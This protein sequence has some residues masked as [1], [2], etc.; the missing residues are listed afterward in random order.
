M[1]PSVFIVI[2]ICLSAILLFQAFQ[3]AS[4]EFTGAK[5]QIQQKNYAEAERLLEADVEKNPGNGEG[6]FWLGNVRG[7]QGDYIGMNEAYNKSLELSQVHAEEIKSNKYNKWAEHLNTGA[8]FLESA[9]PESSMYFDKAIEEFTKAA[10]AWPDTSLTYRYIGYTYNNASRY[11]EAIDAFTAAWEKGRDAESLKRAARLLIVQGDTHKA[12][13]E[14]DNADVL[15][16]LKSVSGVRKNQLKSDVIA[17]LG[18]PDKINRGPRGSKREELVYNRFNLSVSIDNNKV[19]GRKFSKPYV[20]K[21]DSASYTMA[22]KKYDRA[23]ELLQ[24]SKSV[25]SND[26]ETLNLLLNAYVQSNRI[27]EATAEY[28]VAVQSD[29]DNKQSQYILGILYRS[30][31]DYAKAAEHFTRAY[32]LD[33]GFTD[34]LF[35]LGATYYNW[36][37]DIMKAADEKGTPTNEHK[38]KFQKALPYIEKVVEQKP[39]D[40]MVWETLGTIYAQLGMQE[41]AI[42]AFDNADKLRAAQAN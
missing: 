5:L 22:I 9:V 28:E 13:F 10:N 23:S 26:V 18:A 20:P 8:R 7:E 35:D 33:P 14:A 40:F 12:K 34:A 21:I 4:S 6:W 39:D 1:K 42:A 17:A 24:Q 3:C 27:Q 19:T 37:V 31:G 2:T 15:K 16:T 41:K 30:S 25:V 36:G 32:E 29:P 38:D 11:D